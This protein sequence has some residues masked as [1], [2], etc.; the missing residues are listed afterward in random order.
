MASLHGFLAYA[1]VF[2]VLENTSYVM[3]DGKIGGMW[4]GG[5]V[6]Y[7]AVVWMV[8]VLLQ[9]KYFTHDGLNYIPFICMLVNYFCFLQYESGTG[10]IQDVQHIFRNMV[11]QPIVWLS[12]IFCSMVI[13][14]QEVVYKVR[15][16][17]W[18][19]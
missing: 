5:Q 1:C 2:W 14:V 18:N 10:L 4:L 7:G 12:I 8:N 6:V 16:V 15:F 17:L 3:N 11:D 9:A 13:L 19:D